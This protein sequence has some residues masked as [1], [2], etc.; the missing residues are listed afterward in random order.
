MISIPQHTTPKWYT[1]RTYTGHETKVKSAI[2]MEV[3]RQNQEDKIVSIVI[4]QETVFEVRNGKRRQRVKN[5]LPG[6]ILVELVLDKKIHDLITNLPGV[7]GFLAAN[8]KSEPQA[9][10]ADEVARILGRVEERKDVATIEHTFQV[11]D[12]V[13]VIEGPFSNFSGTVKEVNNEKQKI[14]VEVG[15]L[16]RKT[17]VELDFG[18]VEIERPQ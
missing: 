8:A 14:K 15:I 5:F 2:E 7:V 18:Q 12:P 13:K 6:Y 4:P 17:P 3:K 11:G 16:G 1:L 9:L 10:Q